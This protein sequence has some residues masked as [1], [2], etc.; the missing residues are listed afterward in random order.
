MRVL[1]ADDVCSSLLLAEIDTKS[2]QQQNMSSEHC[3]QMKDLDLYFE[4]S[5][6]IHLNITNVFHFRILDI[7]FPFGVYICIY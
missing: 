3:K 2:I 4:C 7:A 6:F 5:I 1:N